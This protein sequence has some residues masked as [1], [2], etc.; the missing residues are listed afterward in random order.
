MY[1]HHTALI[2]WI[3]EPERDSVTH[4]SD[5]LSDTVLS[6]MVL[7]ELYVLLYGST[8][9]QEA[10]SGVS[11]YTPGL[12]GLDFG[13]FG[14]LVC[15]NCKKLDGTIIWCDSKV[16][17]PLTKGQRFHVSSNPRVRQHRPETITFSIFLVHITVKQNV[18]MQKSQN[19]D[20]K[21]LYTL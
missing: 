4:W 9:N 10:T 8:Q 13:W 6:V 18:L 14:W 7:I 17:R 11:I 21:I 15:L 19:I 1:V 16:M 3:Q 5:C 20:I 12:T 2:L